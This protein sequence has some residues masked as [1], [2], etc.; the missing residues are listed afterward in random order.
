MAETPEALNAELL[1]RIVDLEQRI[2]ALQAELAQHHGG[3][4]AAL[5]AAIMTNASNAQ[6]DDREFREFVR[7]L[8]G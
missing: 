4:T 1:A 3:R 8:A 7:R 2:V 5:L 6:M